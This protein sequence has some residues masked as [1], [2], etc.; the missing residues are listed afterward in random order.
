MEYK[1]VEISNLEDLKRSFS[2][3]WCRWKPDENL[4]FKENGRKETEVNVDNTFEEFCHK[5]EQE[6][7]WSWWGKWGQKK[8][9]FKI[10]GT[11]TC[12]CANGNDPVVREW[13]LER[14][15]LLA[16]GRQEEIIPSSEVERLTLHG[17]KARLWIVTGKKRE[18]VD[19]DYEEGK[20]SIGNPEILP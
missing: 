3:E 8:V 16:L 6:T 11:T 5:D 18:Y 17:R 9:S 19:S 20:G 2:M 10:E 12:L 4:H 13:L 7:G 15:P 1:Y 14:C